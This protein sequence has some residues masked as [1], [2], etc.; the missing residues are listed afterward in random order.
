MFRS[1]CIVNIVFIFAIGMFFSC[2]TW[3]ATTSF[4]LKNVNGA[5]DNSSIVEQ[6]L[7]KTFKKWEGVE[8]RWGG[9]NV[10]GI[11]CSAFVRKVLGELNVKLPRTTGEQIKLGTDIQSY[12]LR[13][14]DLV[15]F[16]TSNKTR[17]VGIYLSG[18]R[19]MHASSSHGVTISSL[20]NSYW[21]THF[22]KS[23]RILDDDV[24]MF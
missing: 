20:T 19:F 12:D 3:S 24:K 21:R 9:V 2:Y 1:L 23:S 4:Y 22:E 11:D 5:E 15:F 6:S 14:G 17:H 16:I 13:A 10:S 18:G 7:M 8:Y